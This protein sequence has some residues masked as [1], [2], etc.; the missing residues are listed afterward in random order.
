MHTPP[1]R[2]AAALHGKTKVF[3]PISIPLCYN[4]SIF[5]WWLDQQPFSLD[6]DLNPHFAPL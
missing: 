5:N 4:T 3:I 1:T 2:N 6:L